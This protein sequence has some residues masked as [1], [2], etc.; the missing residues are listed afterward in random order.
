MNNEDFM[1]MNNEDFMQRLEWCLTPYTS[2]EKV[3]RLEW[4]RGA[5]IGNLTETELRL[6]RSELEMWRPLAQMEKSRKG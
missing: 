3:E 5:T 2:T 6:L 1:Q 4:L